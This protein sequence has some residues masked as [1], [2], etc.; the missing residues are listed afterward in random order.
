MIF[1]CIQST[2]VAISVT[3]R[4]KSVDFY[5]LLEFEQ[6][7]L[8]EAEDKTL[9]ITHLRNGEFILELFCYAAPLSAPDFIHATSTDLPVIGT[10][11]FG[12]KVDSIE[13]ARE[14]LAA[15][16]VVASDVKVTQG[17]TGP[18]YFFVA[19]PDGILVEIS[20]DN[21]EF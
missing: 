11:H 12:L 15:K 2:H 5:K 7:H 13:A 19:D 6:V 17:R 20:E 21:R 14:D 9:S 1:T 8:W 4:E 16:A 3:N 18:R 10:K